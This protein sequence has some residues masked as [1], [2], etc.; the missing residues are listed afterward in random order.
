LSR[1][2][3]L[4][5]LQADLVANDPETPIRIVGINGVGLESS[6]EYVASMAVDLPWL[7]DTAGEAVWERWEP[8]WRDLVILDRGNRPVSVINLTEH[9]LDIPSE[10]E[11][12]RNLLLEAAAR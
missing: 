2:G 3:S 4:A 11:A 7:Q 8:E 10:M 6:N 9:N 1:F 5:Q 12:L